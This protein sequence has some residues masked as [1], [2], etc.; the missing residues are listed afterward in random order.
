MLLFR[1]VLRLVPGL[2]YVKYLNRNDVPRVPRFFVCTRIRE[3]AHGFGL[4]WQ[5][6]TVAVGNTF[7]EWSESG[8]GRRSLVV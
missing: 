1:T 4:R 6:E 7:S 3:D 8:A 5:I 2:F